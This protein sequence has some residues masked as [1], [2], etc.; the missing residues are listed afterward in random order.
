MASLAPTTVK[1][2]AR[3]LRSWWQFCLLHNYSPF[4]PLPNQVLDF[5]ATELASVGSYSTLN[6]MRSAISLISKNGVGD[7]PLIKRFCKGASIIKPP[8][9]RYNCV[10]DPSPVIAELGR[11]FPHEDLSLEAVTKKLV[12][13]AALATGQR[14]QTLT[15]LKISQIS[16]HAE[17]VLLRVPDRVK[18]LAGDFSPY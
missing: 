18:T 5:L 10:W 4:D 16:F 12:L 6:T 14:C 1:Q 2:Y 17:R 7:N 13:L 9:P 15:F 11:Q 8:R 3:P